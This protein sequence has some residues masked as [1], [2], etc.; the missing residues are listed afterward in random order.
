M[1]VIAKRHLREFWQRH[2]QAE[3]PLRAWYAHA[4]RATWKGPAAVKAA[5]G[6]NVDFIGDSRL[7]FDIGGNRYR[8]VVRVSYPYQRILIKFIG[9][10]AAYDRINPETV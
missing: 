8:L 9:S 2:P 10:H 1:Q 4:A 7:I 6:G 5:F 3:G